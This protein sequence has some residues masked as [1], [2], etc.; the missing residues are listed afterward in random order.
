MAWVGVDFDATLVEYAPANGAGAPVMNIVTLVK[1]WL[2]RGID[3]RIFT[4]RVDL[5]PDHVAFVDEHVRRIFGRS[6]PITNVKTQGCV[7]LY[8]DIAYRVEAN[9]G[10]LLSG[11]HDG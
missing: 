8:D 9:T 3:V 2:A 4:A 11:R 1:D 10:K 5:G 6:L 7:A